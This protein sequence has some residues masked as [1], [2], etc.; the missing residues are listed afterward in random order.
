[1]RR[2]LR[3]GLARGRRAAAVASHAL[4]ARGARAPRGE[5]VHAARAA[6]AG[7]WRGRS[8]PRPPRRR[9]PAPRAR[10]RRSLADPPARLI[11]P[12]L[13][14]RAD[15]TSASPGRGGGTRRAAR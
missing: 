7:G 10:R 1:A 15:A 13:V 11:A 4:H 5:R 12:A 9:W 6:V 14:A 2:A 8:A 3:A